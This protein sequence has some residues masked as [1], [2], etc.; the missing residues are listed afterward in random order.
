MKRGKNG[1]WY[2]KPGGL[3]IQPIAKEKVFADKWVSTTWAGTCTYRGKLVL[4]AKKF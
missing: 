1:K 4:F 2:H 3:G